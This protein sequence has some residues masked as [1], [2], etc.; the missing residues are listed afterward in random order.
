MPSFCSLFDEGRQISAL[1]TPDH[2]PIVTPPSRLAHLRMHSTCCCPFVRP[3][4]LPLPAHQFICPELQQQ[5]FEKIARLFALPICA[6][7]AP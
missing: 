3:P 1:P 7:I 6:S 4:L 5:R 2:L